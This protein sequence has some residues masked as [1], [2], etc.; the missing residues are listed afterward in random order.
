[1]TIKPET[2]CETIE[3]S[4]GDILEAMRE[5]E[6]YIDISP[7]DFQ[8]IFHIAYRHALR[9]LSDSRKAADIMTC[10]VQCLSIEMDL[11]EAASLLADNRIS[12][13]PV[14]NGA[15][16]I[17]G[18]VSEKDFLAK[19]GVAGSTTFMQI[20]A[21]CLNNKG[22]IATLLR[23]HQ[24]EEIM[25]APAITAPA[26]ISLTKISGL[27]IEKQINRLPI[28]DRTGKPLGIVTRTDL[29]HASCT[30]VSSGVIV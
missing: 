25:T 10:P 30:T 13:A 16:R 18:V 11:I 19:M 15:G 22:C 27:F 23:N 17:V 9:R 28:V 1:M 7:G 12:G 8:E 24:I 5:I 26:E 4:E 29:V 3:I 6:G 21:H 2:A 20:I 14:I